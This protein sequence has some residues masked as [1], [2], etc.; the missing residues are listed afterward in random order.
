MRGTREHSTGRYIIVTKKRFREIRHALAMV[1]TRDDKT[2]KVAIY[3]SSTQYV[4]YAAGGCDHRF[5]IDNF[6]DEHEHIA[7]YQLYV[8]TTS[9][10]DR[11]DEI[12]HY[13]VG[14]KE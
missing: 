5:H 12:R 2:R 10:P 13:L 11:L 14:R 3:D 8:K 4:K 6:M 7:L 1:I 9:E